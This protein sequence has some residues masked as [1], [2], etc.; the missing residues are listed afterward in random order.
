MQASVL[1]SID[2]VAIAFVR[3]LVAAARD[4]G[5]D[6]DAWLRATGIAP[7]ALHAPGAVVT[8]D[9]Y[10]ALFRLAV[11]QLQD[12][13]LGFF[14]RAMRPGS[15]ALVMH[16]L[17]DC[18]TMERA[19]RRLGQGYGLLLDDARFDCLE[20]EGLLGLRL[21]LPAQPTRE[22]EYVHEFLLR[23]FLHSL[24]W[25][26]GGRLRA[27]RIEF[28]IAPPA[29]VTDYR[30]VF[31]GD[32]RFERECSALWFSQ[33]A[34]A[35]PIRRD[36]AALREFLALAPGHVVVPRRTDRTTI[37]RVRRLLQSER[38]RW[39]DLP[40]VAD[41]LHVSVSALQRKLAAEGST[42]QEVRTGLRRDLAM[43]RLHSSDVPLAEV[44]AELGFADNAAFQRA[45][46]AWTGMAPGAYRLHGSTPTRAAGSS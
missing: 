13:G 20:Q 4:R 38:P 28:A 34:L 11:Q 41:A 40:A 35:E 18:G 29:H 14:S 33:R 30:T 9:Q 1:P 8:A 45:F 37:A 22:R 10:I 3:G 36:G 12:E 15:Y 27:E 5:C 32:V 7:L 25:L 31:P 24:V 16:A 2:T 6:V 26:Q 46:K 43:V 21:H 39:P 17:M 19:V 23:V 42:F 44:A